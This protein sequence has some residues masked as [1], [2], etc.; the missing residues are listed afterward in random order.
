MNEFLDLV[1]ASVKAKAVSEDGI[2][3]LILPKDFHQDAARI[4]YFAFAMGDIIGI[5]EEVPEKFRDIWV[6]H[7]QTCLEDS[8]QFC[9]EL[10]EVEIAVSR[11]TLSP[12]DFRE[13]L[14]IRKSM[15]AGVL[16]VQSENVF[17]PF[18]EDSLKALNDELRRVER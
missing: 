3:Y 5:S 9:S 4:P 15:L 1:N 6:S 11:A 17:K 14:S 7:E 10:T 16:A 13:F 12:S 2:E 18:W 8:S